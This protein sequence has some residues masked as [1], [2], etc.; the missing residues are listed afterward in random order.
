MCQ[1]QVSEAKFA[2]T[3]GKVNYQ[4]ELMC[5]IKAAIANR[6]F[7]WGWIYRYLIG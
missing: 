2:S 3:K 4:Q 6:P 1:A 5:K 7:A